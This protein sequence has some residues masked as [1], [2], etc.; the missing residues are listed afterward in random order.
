MQTLQSSHSPTPLLKPSEH[1]KQNAG[2][3]Q[4]LVWTKAGDKLLNH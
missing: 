2:E 3:K 1:Q 4:A